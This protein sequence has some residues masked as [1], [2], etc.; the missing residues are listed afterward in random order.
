MLLEPVV[1]AAL[2]TGVAQAGPPPDI[3]A[4][5]HGTSLIE[6]AP[7]DFGPYRVGSGPAYTRRKRNLRQ[8]WG[9]REAAGGFTA[10]TLTGAIPMGGLGQEGAGKGPAL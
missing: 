4:L 3:G 2:R 8:P 9:E 7:K 10:R 1:V 5:H 6:L